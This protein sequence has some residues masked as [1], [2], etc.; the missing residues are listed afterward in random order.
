MRLQATIGGFGSIETNLQWG[1]YPIA[2]FLTHGTDQA[3]LSEGVAVLPSLVNYYEKSDPR[4][5]FL[6]KGAEHSNCF[7][8]TP[9]RS[10]LLMNCTP[11][12][13]PEIKIFFRHHDSRLNPSRPS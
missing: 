5:P 9:S 2:H 8:S 13:D 7:A 11:S 12:R 4:K 6:N 10:L 1:L 3:R